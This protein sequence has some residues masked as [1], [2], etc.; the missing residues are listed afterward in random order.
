TILSSIRNPLYGTRRHTASCTV[1]QILSENSSRTGNGSTVIAQERICESARR[2]PDG[3]SL[4]Q[5]PR[6]A[7]LGSVPDHSKKGGRDRGSLGSRAKRT[8]CGTIG[9]QLSGES[10]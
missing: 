4:F 8:G 10:T 5:G 2:R 7:P 6:S 3:R 9:H 1:I